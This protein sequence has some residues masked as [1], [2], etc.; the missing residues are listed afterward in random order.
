VRCVFTL[1][2]YPWTSTAPGAAQTPGGFR[3][4]DLSLDDAPFGRLPE[5]GETL[6]FEDG[7]AARIEAIGW[8]LDGAAYLYLGQRF[9]KDG[10]A[11]ATWHARGFVDRYPVPAPPPQPAPAPTAAPPTPPAPA[12]APAAP[13]AP[14]GGQAPP[15]PPAA[16]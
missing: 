2:W 14:P 11:I 10:E 15:P 8:K 13:P 6:F 7:G 5:V 3:T 4:L 1:V 16:G 9:E 12:P